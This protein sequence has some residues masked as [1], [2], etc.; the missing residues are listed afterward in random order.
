MAKP[1]NSSIEALRE[2]VMAV[3]N[4]GTI[5][6]FYFLDDQ[7]QGKI[8]NQ[9]IFLK[10]QI[11]FEMMVR[12]GWIYDYAC[13]RYSLMGLIED[14]GKPNIICGRVM[15]VLS[16]SDPDFA[17]YIKLSPSLQKKYFEDRF[18]KA[19][20]AFKKNLNKSD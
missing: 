15:P 14:F 2:L 11:Y 12:L 4:K 10:Q 8:D 6:K 3:L 16:G 13:Q 9:V 7:Q 17:E 20:E 5:T 19:L 1:D 18:E